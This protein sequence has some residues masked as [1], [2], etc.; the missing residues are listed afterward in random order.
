[1]IELLWVLMFVIVP[2][3]SILWLLVFIFGGEL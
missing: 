1:M 3:V 2:F